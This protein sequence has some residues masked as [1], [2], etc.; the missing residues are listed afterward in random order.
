MLQDSPNPYQVAE[1]RVRRKLNFY[2]S[3]GSYVIVCGLLWVIALMTNGGWW[4]VWVMIGW[5]FGLAWQ[6][7]D[8][9][10]PQDDPISRQRQI[11]E[12]MRRNH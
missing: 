12:E 3:L 9:F 11:E 6:A 5:G 10:G 8:V 2:R 4:P 1:R 7:W